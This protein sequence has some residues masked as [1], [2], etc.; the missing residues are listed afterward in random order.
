MN[1]YIILITLKILFL[2]SSAYAEII[3][4]FPSD[5]IKQGSLVETTLKVD[6]ETAQKFPIQKL[7]GET[8]GDVL[9]F[10]HISP[11]IRKNEDGA[12][13]ADATVIFAKVP[14]KNSVV[15]NSN[16]GQVTLAW[17]QIEIINTEAD[18]KLI[19]ADFTIP[20]KKN[21]WLLILGSLIVIVL[22]ILAWI[23]GSRWKIKQQLKRKKL[24]LK[25]KLISAGSYEEVVSLWQKKSEFL[26]EFGYLEE[27]F[28]DL[29]K[30][31]FKYQFK[32]KQ[33]D[34]EK[35]EVMKAYR[36]FTQKTEGGING[37]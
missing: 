23:L 24:D 7:K 32:P 4:S 33:T 8:V 26:K 25:Q 15:Y 1:K 2:V 5:R 9:H 6:L 16:S 37:I 18:Q 17:P 35:E 10:H 20:G 28:R 22:F 30:T 31:L 14:E 34:I 27:P 11:L 12:F 3:L 13:Y 29:E 21:V 19:F 36:A